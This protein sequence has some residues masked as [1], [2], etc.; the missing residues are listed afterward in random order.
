MRNNEIKD[1][2]Y[3]IKKWEEK[4]KEDLHIWFWAIW[5]YNFGDNIFTG[6]INIDKAEM[7]QSI[8]LKNIVEFCSNS[9]PRTWETKDKK[10]LM[11]VHAY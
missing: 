4:I 8:Q 7:D 5:N 10:T 2:I 9:R 6:K 11:K 1:E 3:E